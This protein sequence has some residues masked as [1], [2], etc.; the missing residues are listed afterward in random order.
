MLLLPIGEAKFHLL[1]SEIPDPNLRIRE[2]KQFGSPPEF[3]T[4]ALYLPP[5]FL[6]ALKA[7]YPGIASP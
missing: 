1:I 2:T 3:E 6:L 5:P 4:F 7:E